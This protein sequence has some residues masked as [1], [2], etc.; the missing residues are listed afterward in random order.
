MP[1]ETKHDVSGK[2]RKYICNV[3]R[4]Y[5]NNNTH[6]I[7]QLAVQTAYLL[8]VEEES[9]TMLSQCVAWVVVGCNPTIVIIMRPHHLLK[10]L[11]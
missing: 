2:K 5:N 4:N 1:K 3:T 6:T 10:W 8:V 11:S 9:Y 7:N